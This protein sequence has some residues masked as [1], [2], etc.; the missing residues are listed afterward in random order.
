MKAIP[1]AKKRKL[2]PNKIKV[3]KGPGFAFSSF[4]CAY[5]FATSYSSARIYLRSSPSRCDRYTMPP[6]GGIYARRCRL[7]SITLLIVLK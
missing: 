4:S 3:T 5:L 1:H 2:H 6:D 7:S